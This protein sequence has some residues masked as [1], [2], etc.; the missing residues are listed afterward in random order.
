[1]SHSLTCWMHV[2]PLALLLAGCTSVFSAGSAREVSR[3]K[4]LQLA[5]TGAA[6]HIR[7]MGSDRSYHYVYD[8]RPE[9]QKSYKVRSDQIKLQSTFDVGED[10]YVLHP[11]LIEGKLLG[12]K[13]EY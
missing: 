8:S 6:D 13:P 3:E 11:W 10:S 2:T 4:L 1:M 7:Y 9:K 12:K 5:D